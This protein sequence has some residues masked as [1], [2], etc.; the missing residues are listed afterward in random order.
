MKRLVLL[1]LAVLHS[2]SVYA[3]QDARECAARVIQLESL[4]VEL[5]VEN[6][7]LGHELQKVAESTEYGSTG[8]R[9][10]MLS[11]LSP[12]P[13]VCGVLTPVPS[14]VPTPALTT[15]VPTTTPIPTPFTPVPTPFVP[16]PTTAAPSA[17]PSVSPVPT[18]A[19]ITT[20]EQLATAVADNATAEIVIEADV[21]LPHSQYGLMVF[22]PRTLS[23]MGRAADNGGR[24][25]LDGQSHSRLFWVYG[26]GAVLYLSELNLAN[27][28][29]LQLDAHCRPDIY[30]CGGGFLLV[31]EGARL[32]MSSCDILGDG[33][34]DVSYFGGAMLANGPGTV[35]DWFNV[36]VADVVAPWQAIFYLSTGSEEEPIV[37][38]FV[39]CQF[40]RCRTWLNAANAV[41]GFNNVYATF[42]D[43]LFA[44]NDGVALQ[45]CV[46]PKTRVE[47]CV[48]RA[49]RANDNEW[50]YQGS[51][52]VFQYGGVH[53]VIDTVFE[54]N[55]GVA[56][57]ESG[58]VGVQSNANVLLR[59]VTFLGNYGGYKGGI[60]A[61]MPTA[62]VTMENCYCYGNQASQEAVILIDS[63]TLTMVNSTIVASSTTGYT[64]LS[65][66]GSVLFV[67]GCVFRENSIVQSGSGIRT[68]E[69]GTTTIVDC[70]FDSN[71][72][73][74]NGGG[75]LSI[76]TG[77][78][79]NV[80]RTVFRN[81]SGY[82]CACFSVGSISVL[83]IEDSDII[84]CRAEAYAGM[85]EV[86]NGGKLEITG[87]RISGSAASTFGSLARVKTG[88]VLRIASSTIT[89]CSGDAAFAVYD[90][91]DEDF[92]V[93]FDTTVVDETVT[94]LSRGDVL[95][96]N[97]EGFTNEI[98]K[99]ASIG[100]CASATSQCL[101]DSCSDMAIGIDCACEVDGE[102]IPFPVDCMTSAVI[103][104]A[105]P[106][107]H[108]LKYVIT[109]PHNDT[110][111]FVLANVGERQMTW[112]LTNSSADPG[113]VTL[114][115]SPKSGVIQPFG[116]IVVAVVAMTRGLNARDAAYLG[117]F[118]LFSEDVCVCRDQSLE[119]SIELFVVAET[120]SRNSYVELATNVQASG[121]LS[122]HIIPVDDE[123]LLIQDSGAVQF[124]PVLTW[125]GA[126]TG[127]RR[128]HPLEEIVV[129]C[130][131]KFLPVLD[132][133]V[134]TCQMPK[135]NGVPLAGSFSLEVGLVS[136]EL[137]GGG[138]Y[139]VEVTSC[140]EHYFYNVLDDACQLCDLKKA[141]CRGGRELPVPKKGYWSDL[142][143]AELGY[144]YECSMSKANCKGGL[145][146]NR[147]CF[148]GQA[149]VD[150]C[151]PDL[152]SATSE[153]PLC[154]RCKWESPRSY[155]K[156]ERCFRC[157]GGEAASVLIVFV[158][159]TIA[160][161]MIGLV[162]YRFAQARSLTYRIYRRVFD[163]GRFKV[164]WVN[165]Q[166]MTTV[167]WNLQ[168]DWP[169][170]SNVVSH[171]D[172]ISQN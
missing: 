115:A 167:G 147:S 9:R 114:D 1:V 23:I 149:G 35:V 83:T 158:I 127:A 154:G 30:I 24:V 130:G 151:A 3:K 27:G 61:A 145:H 119:M 77:A 164:V 39:G 69:D 34:R 137:V 70:V 132:L 90:E 19:G 66:F 86:S 47:R 11:T 71:R 105:V 57:L 92:R 131:V 102:I 28:S 111:Q 74:E 168:I 82:S 94:I 2:G 125:I 21:K 103:D 95:I 120:S 161:V 36:T 148:E 126:R 134:G 97:S 124:S 118:Q 169:E 8:S 135:Y 52:L 140:P 29:A 104:V 20:Y 17:S 99:N 15:G 42:R 109:K 159:F 32:V 14:V 45:M 150:S 128:R 68:Q 13:C 142:E 141:E 98:A 78:I 85:A 51:A 12:T 157:K 25:T 153:G 33:T 166:I 87:S 81:N 101:R 22:S 122:F 171:K 63:A 89:K 121:D 156:N 165:Y 163:I 139:S 112:A 64:I 116:E 88:S 31:E 16:G 160:P 108:T 18:T 96:Q 79:V 49:N 138:E 172:L 100:T 46:S 144:V 54:D 146:H 75:L 93:R 143:N 50:P 84:G 41:V 65:Q 37:G 152:C 58:A 80:Y 26:S 5:Q 117:Y 106:S 43:C 123:G 48:F 53:E 91:S 7:R 56:T 72:G 133:H 155:M 107:T 67:S 10:R 59:N 4:V 76:S 110:V 60:L 40:V 73:T 38:T 62:I 170:V 129:I 44:D 113:E 55:V 162:V 6:E 136:G